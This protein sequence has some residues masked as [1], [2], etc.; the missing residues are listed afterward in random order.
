VKE[1]KIFPDYLKKNQELEETKGR[2]RRWSRKAIPFV[3]TRDQ[4]KSIETGSA[5]KTKT[6]RKK[7]KERKWLREN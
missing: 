1:R 3:E 7:T 2:T 5:L 6:Q 4:G